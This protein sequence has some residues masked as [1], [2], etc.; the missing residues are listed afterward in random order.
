VRIPATNGVPANVV[1][2]VPEQPPPVVNVELTLEETA[3]EIK[4][5]RDQF[6]QLSGARVQR[7]LRLSDA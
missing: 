1:V 4:L 6:G 2:N 3:R 7:Q 5:E